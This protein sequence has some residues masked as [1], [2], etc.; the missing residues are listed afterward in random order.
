MT[1][2]SLSRNIRSVLS[3]SPVSQCQMWLLFSSLSS[4]TMVASGSSALCGTYHRL[5]GFVFHLDRRDAVGRGV[6]IGGQHGGHLLAV[7]LHRV[8]RQHHLGIAHQ[9][10]HPGQVV[11]FQVLAGYDR[12]DPVDGQRLL[13]IDALD[14][15]MRHRAPHD[16]EVKHPGELHVIDVVALAPDEPRVL[17]A[18]DRVSHSTDFGRCSR[19]H[20]SLL[21]RSFSAA[22][23]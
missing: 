15:R 13:G 5:Q 19:S 21:A 23:W 6:A 14:P 11:L 3:L 16:V 2:T 22:D 4:L 7:E 18:G 20:H 17:L 1:V 8:H 9:G 10:G 12:Q